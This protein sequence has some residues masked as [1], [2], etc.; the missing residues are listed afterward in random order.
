MFQ[1]EAQSPLLK[2]TPETLQNEVSLSNL[3]NPLQQYNYFI[4]YYN[5]RENCINNVQLESLSSSNS[6][7]FHQFWKV[8]SNNCLSL[9]FLVLILV[10]FL[11]IFLYLGLCLAIFTYFFALQTHRRNENKIENPLDKM[12]F[13]PE[14]C[15]SAGLPNKIYEI[16][17][18]GKRVD[19]IILLTSEIEL[20]SLTINE[21]VRLS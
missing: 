6:A 12:I 20:K 16:R 5:R 8:F 11:G 1:K 2:S 9:I 19:E 3:F 15:K 21:E 13:C 7:V 10:P 14:M 18:E 17:V 4:E